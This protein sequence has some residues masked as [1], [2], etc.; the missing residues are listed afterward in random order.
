MRGTLVANLPA[1]RRV[2][3]FMP[4]V[5]ARSWN[6]IGPPHASKQVWGLLACALIEPTA[7]G[8]TRPSRRE[9]LGFSMCRDASVVFSGIEKSL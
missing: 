7:T 6:C 9:G 2:E 1:S 4:K 5:S 3:Y 8:R